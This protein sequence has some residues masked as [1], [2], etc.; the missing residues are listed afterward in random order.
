[1]AQGEQAAPAGS[2]EVDVATAMHVPEG[3]LLPYWDEVVGRTDYAPPNP[4]E[5]PPSHLTRRELIMYRLMAGGVVGWM[6]SKLGVKVWTEFIWPPDRTDDR[7]L[8]EG[9]PLLRGERP[10][11]RV[12]KVF[13]G[14]GRKHGR[15]Y[16]EWIAHNAY[17]TLAS[18]NTTLPLYSD[19]SNEG[20]TPADWGRQIIDVRRFATEMDAVAISAAGSS[21]FAGLRWALRM[22]N[23]PVTLGRCVFI[24]AVFDERGFSD[25]PVGKIASKYSEL[26]DGTVIDKGGMWVVDSWAKDRRAVLEEL[27]RNPFAWF[28]RLYHE[29]THG[30]PPVMMGN[31]IRTVKFGVD[32]DR[33]WQELAPVI[34]K[35]TRFLYVYTPDDRYVNNR[36]SLDTLARFAKRFDIPLDV[37]VTP[38]GIGH[39]DVEAASLAIGPWL[40]LRQKTRGD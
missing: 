15:P 2:A 17:N 3:R 14:T 9:E 1:M 7:W 32:L 34:T 29:A 40:G 21:L 6:L 30:S 31:Q 18:D 12:V 23:Q 13:Q 27:R 39:A 35:K 33:D 25:K 4:A 36:V 38:P 24:N 19:L 11:E 16:C 5:Q 22:G 20:A 28:G 26:S 10:I 37:L 8:P